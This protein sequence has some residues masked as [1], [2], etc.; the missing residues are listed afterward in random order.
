MTYV[1]VEYTQFNRFLRFSVLEFQSAI[2]RYI[3]LPRYCRQVLGLIMNFGHSVGAI[4]TVDKELCFTLAF[5]ADVAGLGEFK[6]TRFCKKVEIYSVLYVLTLNFGP[7]F[8]AS[9]IPISG[10]MTRV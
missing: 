1:D 2:T 5:S 6:R 8:R 7:E 3:I 4:D 10:L 9:I